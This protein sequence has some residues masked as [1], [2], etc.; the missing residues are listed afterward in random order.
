MEK[1]K[2]YTQLVLLVVSAQAKS[3]SGS[4][5]AGAIYF[6]KYDS[7]FGSVDLPKKYSIKSSCCISHMED[8]V[9]P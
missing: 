8:Y 1:C 4:S 7:N 5:V 3:I 6:T 9:E 2:I